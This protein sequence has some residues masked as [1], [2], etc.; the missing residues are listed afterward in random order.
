MAERKDLVPF[1][2]EKGLW[3]YMD[4]TSHKEVIPPKYNLAYPFINSY[5]IVGFEENGQFRFGVI[6]S[7][8]NYALY[9]EYKLI[10]IENGYIHAK[11]DNIACLFDSKMKEV[12]P[13]IYEDIRS[14]DSRY[15][16][17]KKNGKWGCYDIQEQRENI[18]LEYNEFGIY[19][20][21][22]G[23]SN[24]DSFITLNQLIDVKELNQDNV[25]IIDQGD[26]RIS[27]IDKTGKTIFSER[28][29]WVGSPAYKEGLMAFIKRDGNGKWGFIDTDGKL[30]IP[31]TYD[32][33]DTFGFIGGF[34]V[35]SEKGENPTKNKNAVINKSNELVLPFTLDSTYTILEDSTILIYNKQIQKSKLVDNKLNEIIPYRYESIEYIEYGFYRGKT[36]G[37]YAVI[38]KSGKERLS[39]QF[40]D[41]SKFKNGMCIVRGTTGEE[42]FINTQAELI[43]PSKY[44][45]EYNSDDLFGNGFVYTKNDSLAFQNKTM[46]LDK[47]GREYIVKMLPVRIL[48]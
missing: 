48:K 11:K 28:Y 16:F 14:A 12:I 3:G 26:N 41:I 44:K 9:P 32:F 45:I 43:I 21:M 25:R 29:G 17:V 47:N 37:L 46:L 10:Y 42:G 22:P 27:V 2:N 30:A 24:G 8:D 13:C 33:V 23:I 6:D 34:A 7:L 38:D 5:A 36:N 31:Y 20:N 35:V 4:Y 1:D 15:F 39:A 40:A 18:P 19:N